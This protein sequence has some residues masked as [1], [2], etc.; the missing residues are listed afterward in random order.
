MVFMKSSPAPHDALT[1]ISA[2]DAPAAD[3]PACKETLQHIRRVRGWLDSTEAQ[4]TSQLNRLSREGRSAAPV[5]EHTRSSGCSNAEA[6]RREKRAKALEENPSFGDGLES[7]DITSGH[8]D[9]LANAT[10]N[11]DDDIKERLGEHA[12]DLLDSAKSRTPDEFG[13]ECRE[14]IAWLEREAGVDRA[15]Q[16]KRDAWVQCKV[17]P[18]TGMYNL[19]GK[20]PPEIGSKVKRA[21]DRQ[22]NAEHRR[23]QEAVKAGEMSEDEARQYGPGR[24]NADAL[25]T[26]VGAGHAE[27]R[28]TEPDLVVTVHWFDLVN[29]GLCETS[30]GN[31]LP[32]EV[33]Q[34]LSCMANIIIV[35][36]DDSGVPT[37]LG[38]TKRYPN[39]AQRRALRAI[40][41]TC[42]IDG[43][44]TEFDRCEIHHVIPW[45]LHGP[46]DLENLVPLCSM[47][48]HRVAHGSGW[49]MMLNPSTRALIVTSPT[50]ERRTSYPDTHPGRRPTTKRGRC[51]GVSQ[52]DTHRAGPTERTESP[53]PTSARSPLPEPSLF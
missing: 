2:V 8:V 23:I 7:G 9:A 45:E 47:H 10:G 24:L 19:S 43:C 33:A 26:L 40:Y 35:A 31:L 1:A 46:T 34:R 6:R 32:A 27:Q 21:L 15:E 48:H 25:G 36:L 17:D 29:G 22:A 37:R 38:N 44:N 12:D 3:A 50:G 5:D 11:L 16:Q 51:T 52:R 4:I 14:L 13:R 53:E 49:S 39:R 28:P 18:K 20:L 42:A 30:D 41:R